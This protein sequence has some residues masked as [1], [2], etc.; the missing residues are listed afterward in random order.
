[1][2]GTHNLT[3]V[4]KG[5]DTELSISVIIDNTTTGSGSELLYGGTKL[6]YGTTYEVR[7]QTSDKLH[8]ALA[9]SLEFKTPDEP[10][11]L[12]KIVSVDDE[13][14]NSTTLTLSSCLLSVGDKYELKVT[15]TPLSSKSKANHETTITFT[16]SSATENIVT[17]SLYP[18]EEAIVKYGHSYC[19]DWMKV[20]DGTSIFVE[21][22]TCVFETPKE[23]SRICSCTVAYLNKERSEVTISLEGMA[24][25]DSLGSVWV[26]FEGTFWKYS[27]MRR[28]SE[29]LCEADFL[30]ASEQSGT[31][32]KYEGNYTV[33][34][35]ADE[36]STLLVD[37][38]IT[39]RIPA[40]PSF[41]A[42][43]FEFTNSL[44]TG[45]IAVLTGKDLVIGTEY[46]V[47][48]NTSH[49]FS[50]VVKSPT[51]AE[52]PEM[53]I[54]FDESLPFCTDI[55]I[56]AITP[57]DE[58]SGIALT[59][60]SF[61]GK[62]PTR[63][64]VIEIFVDTETGQNGWTCGDSSRPCSTMD[65]AWKIM[66][67]LDIMNPTFSLLT[68]TSLSSQMTIG[69]GM[70]VLIQN[71]TH[72]EPSL[73][74]P[75]SAAESSTSALIVVSSALLNIQNIDIVVGSSNPSFVLISASSSK[76]ILKDGLM[77]IN[78]STAESRNELEELCVW[79]TGLIELI[80]TELKVK[81]NEFFN[82][83]QGVISMKG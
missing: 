66:R 22:E 81:N 36:A 40:P 19:V 47:K 39:V 80:E 17:L 6:K 79:K 49:T 41:T 78:S 20:V 70:S 38:G 26:S 21:T 71:G 43:K 57:T 44:G 54:G 37:S 58:A 75:S 59:P 73:N 5:T 25:G 4:E 29:T 15:G 46:E 53:L 24:L 60:S 30:V 48:L 9:A 50:I 74:I 52:S 34:S 69:S 23:P 77:T 68:G 31:H 32:L 12:V 51:R 11:R 63:P 27:S 16:A 35:K 3:F 2:S 10:S 82:I 64:D 13:G 76:M 7:S 55:L 56:E 67:A 72:D 65:A 1:M 83:S 14:L 28:I 45:C 8:F 18:F 42:V 61:T 33:C 62:T